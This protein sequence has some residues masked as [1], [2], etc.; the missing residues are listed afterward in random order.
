MLAIDEE[1]AVLYSEDLTVEGAWLLRSNLIAAHAP[2]RRAT[3]NFDAHYVVA[4]AVCSLCSALML[5]VLYCMDCYKY[6][7]LV[8]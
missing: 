6:V 7:A 8:C 4:P 2:L 5:G 1:V 3:L